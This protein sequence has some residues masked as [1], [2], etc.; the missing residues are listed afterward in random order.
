MRIRKAVSQKGLHG[1]KASQHSD[2]EDLVHRVSRGDQDAWNEFYS[3]YFRMISSAVKTYIR[4]GSDDEADLVQEVF[5]ALFAALRRYEP[6][7]SVEAYIFEIHATR[8]YK[9]PQKRYGSQKGRQ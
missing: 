5:L 6:S 7:K 3:R 8:P 4:P 9:Q 2:L 1:L